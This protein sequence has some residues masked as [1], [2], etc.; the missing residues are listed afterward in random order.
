[1]FK[2]AAIGARDDFF[3]LGGHSLLAVQLFSM[4]ER[5]FGRALPM[6][7]LWT[8]PTAE[9]LA[10]LV[11]ESSHPLHPLAVPMS[12]LG[13]GAPLF[14][15]PGLG[16][17]P[18]RFQPLVA[19]MH[20]GRP[21]IGL[22]YPGHDGS[23]AP[24]DSIEG[25]AAELLAAIDSVH[26]S[27]PVHLLGYSLGGLVAFEIA[28]ALQQRPDRAGLLV[29]L[30]AYAPGAAVQH[31]TLRRAWAHAVEA[32]EAGTVRE[33]AA[34][35]R[36]RAMRWIDRRASKL[37]WLYRWAAGNPP[38]AAQ[39]MRD[40]NWI[41]GMRYEAGPLRGAI[42]VLRSSTDRNHRRA[43]LNGWNA[44]VDGPVTMHLL[45]MPHHDLFDAEGIDELARVMTDVLLPLER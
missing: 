32:F 40:A 3:S 16:G 23:V 30:D 20:A 37:P 1:L 42:R 14:V 9:S 19:R 17:H 29:M 28:R 11:A 10:R 35:L 8:H 33:I 2:D 7:R 36:E 43:E 41:A 27:G 4:I 5:R 12:S 25:I 34:A 21:V 15:I 18:V 24:L 38:D 6:A 45:S 44:L 31:G 13:S 39:R 22:A 26:P